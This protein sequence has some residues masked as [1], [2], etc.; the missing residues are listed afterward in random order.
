M[1][2]NARQGFWNGTLPL[3]GYRIVEADEQHGQAR[4]RMRTESS[5]Y[6]RDHLPALAQHIE[7]DAKEVRIIII[8]LGSIL[9]QRPRTE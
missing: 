8:R 2:E 6:R 3:I 5:G 1:K 4:K 7:V 9:L